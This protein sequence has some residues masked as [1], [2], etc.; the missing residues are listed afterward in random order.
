MT[1]CKTNEYAIIHIR[2]YDIVLKQKYAKED[3]KKFI[4]DLL[5]QINIM[6]D[7]IDFLEHQIDLADGR[8]VIVINTKEKLKK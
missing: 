4:K 6:K 2:D 5:M 3:Y 7:H 1:S 8:N